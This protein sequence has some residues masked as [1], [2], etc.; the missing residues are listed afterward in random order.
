MLDMEKKDQPKESKLNV[1]FYLHQL[2][3]VNLSDIIR[4]QS[5]KDLT[6]QAREILTDKLEGMSIE[7]YF[8]N[9]MGDLAEFITAN[10]I[11]TKDRKKFI[12]SIMKKL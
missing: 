11:K 6:N 5:D 3:I 8:S 7:D 4:S 1:Q 9:A 10:G 2:N 12:Y